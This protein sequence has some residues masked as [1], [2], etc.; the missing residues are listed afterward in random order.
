MGYVKNN[1]TG[2]IHNYSRPMHACVISGVG[3]GGG[4]GMSTM[5]K[6]GGGGGQIVFCAPHIKVVG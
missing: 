1:P 2:D 4:G 6:L 5:K 3:K